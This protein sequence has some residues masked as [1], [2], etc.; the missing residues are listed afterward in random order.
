MISFTPGGMPAPWDGLLVK[1][2]NRALDSLDLL[3][4]NQPVAMLTPDGMLLIAD[5]QG[6]LQPS[7]DMAALGRAFYRAMLGREPPT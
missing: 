3:I 2:N 7:N 5:D 6:E 1:E 4:N